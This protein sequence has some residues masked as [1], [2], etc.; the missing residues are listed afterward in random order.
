VRECRFPA[1]AAGAAAALLVSLQSGLAAD[2]PA[3]PIPLP[4]PAIN[5]TGLYFGGMLGVDFGSAH[6]VRPQS[7]LADTAIGSAAR[8]LDV[9]G[10]AGFNYQALPWLVLGVEGQYS[11]LTTNYRE[12]GPDIDFLQFSKRLAAVTGRVGLVLT[13][14]TMVYAK[15]GPGW[16]DVRGVQGFGTPFQTTLHGALIATGIETLVLPNLALRTEISY[17][18]T[19]DTLVLNQGF[20]QYQP[21]VFQAIMGAAYKLDPPPGWGTP[22]SESPKAAPL[23]VKAPPAA[24]ATAAPHWTGVEVGGFG[25]LNGDK[26]KFLGSFFGENNEQGPYTEPAFGGGWF[27][28]ANVQILPSA[29]AGIELSGNYQKAN[30]NDPVGAGF[31]P[32]FFHFASISE[33]YALSLRLGWLPTPSTLIYGK[34]GPATLRVTPDPNYWNAVS[35]TNN[36]AAQPVTLEG[37]Q[38]GAGAE[39]FL[40]SYLSL[41]VEATYTQVIPV[42]MQLVFVGNQ[43]QPIRLVPA[44][45]TT[46]LGAAV[47][48]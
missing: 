22:S 11:T 42:G 43:P 33:S 27:A 40:T 23:F 6:Y 30:F 26:M 1:L 38:Y 37:F 44:L 14:A 12:L 9:G 24:A 46:S 25:S 16:L 28:G 39:T 36:A 4:P 47:H 5:W 3:R 2:M 7:G 32:T 41:R 20:D 18:K 31:G 17:I 10:Y 45:L 8:G 13:P 35:P 48:F 15:A 21:T 34:I 19:R 29:V